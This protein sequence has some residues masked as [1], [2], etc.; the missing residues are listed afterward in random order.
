MDQHKLEALI[1]RYE[2][3]YMF[4]T[5]KIASMIAEQIK[6]ITM[7]QYFAIRYLKKNSPCTSS[8]LADACGVNRSAI[9]A[10]VDRLVTKGFVQRI[11]DEGDRRMVYLESTEAGD[12]VYLEGE[13]KIRQLVESYLQ[14]L[15]EDEV[16]AFVRIY[17]KIVHIIRKNNGGV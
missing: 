14:E 10:M 17:E 5:R 13:E 11:R 8:E 15:E 12:R 16:E 1:H 3:V 4:A 2:E 6:E 9:T 7:E